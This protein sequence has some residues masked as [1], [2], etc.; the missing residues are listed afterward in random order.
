[1]NPERRGRGN[2]EQNEERD[3]MVDFKKI[4][5]EIQNIAKRL[6]VKHC[7]IYGGTVRD[8]LRRN[9]SRDISIIVEREHFK[10]IVKLLSQKFKDKKG[11]SIRSILGLGSKLF[12]TSIFGIL[13]RI[14]EVSR[15]TDT[16]SVRS[17]LED[18]HKNCDFTVNSMF[19][20]LMTLNHA[21]FENG[22]DF[23]DFCGAM[24]DLDT[25]ILKCTDSIE[26][27][28][29]RKFGRFMRLIRISEENGFKID[30]RIVK[31]ILEQSYHNKWSYFDLIK[32]DHEFYRMIS[33]DYFADIINVFFKLQLN[34]L[35][36]DR[37]NQ[38]AH[39]FIFNKLKHMPLFDSRSRDK[40]IY[41]RQDYFWEV[42]VEAT[43][44]RMNVECE[45]WR[46][47]VYGIHN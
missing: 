35:I 37:Y 44:K 13:V 2:Q 29:D 3:F 23:H 32:H 47:I 34:M 30:K 19:I 10:N 45:R 42:L 18:E 8:L 22:F 1:M 15:R 27:T 31:Y 26:R 28:F 36:D 14:R 7:Y 24:R 40:E 38:N 9:Y 21:S 25:G 43:N 33:S 17:L 20:D 16:S 6:R 4:I 41:M 39:A 11:H 5:F 12:K 46:P